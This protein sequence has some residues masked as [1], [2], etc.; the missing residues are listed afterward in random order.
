MK[1]GISSFAFGWAARTPSPPAARSF[2]EANLL[3]FALTHR[4]P[5]I[6]FGDNLPLH[7]L[8][9][10]RLV[11]LAQQTRANSIGIEVG[12]RRMTAAHLQR[13]IELS[14]GLGARILRFVVDEA[15][16]M[17]GPA[18]I[19]AIVREAL[20]ALE[21]AGLVLGIENHDRF[22][23]AT[24][25]RIVDE[26]DSEHV[27]VCVDTANSL[28][29]GEGLETVLAALAPVCVNLH[30]KDFE[31]R[32]VP[33]KMGFTVRGC[34]LGRGL[35]PLDA[36][37]YAVAQSGRC[38]SAIV[39]LWTPPEDDIAVTIEKEARWAAESVPVLRAA[40]ERLPAGRPV[41]LPSGVRPA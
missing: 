41:H 13:Y 24:L 30:V 28:G 16:Y 23:C 35:L 10:D 27:G 20:P 19:V 9:A 39:E 15:D 29:A 21:G 33:Y 25:R 32:R 11:R 4:L 5:L 6:Q 2:S 7:A 17:P 34:V 26:L 3:G 1:P 22:S 8:E 12:A 18:E 38:A 37:L 36:T 40:L 14:R 31:I